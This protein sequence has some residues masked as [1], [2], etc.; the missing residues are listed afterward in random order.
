[1]STIYNY[2]NRI[3]S[4]KYQNLISN[5][6][7]NPFAIEIIQ[8][9]IDYNIS[10]I[11]VGS[12][13]TNYTEN[14]NDRTFNTT[15]LNKVPYLTMVKQ[16]DNCSLFKLDQTEAK[17]YAEAKSN[18]DK[19][20]FFDVSYAT[21]HVINNENL[22][23]YL[24][25]SGFKKLNSQELETWLQEKITEGNAPNSTLIMTMGTIPDTIADSLNNETLIVKYLRAGGRITWI[26]D[27]PLFYQSHNNGT[28][29]TWG[30]AGA[31]KMLGVDLKIWD[32]NSTVSIITS[33]GEEWGMSLPDFGTSQRP[34]TEKSVSIVLA[35]VQGYASSWLKNYNSTYPNSGFIRYSYVDYDGANDQRNS[36]VVNL[37]TIP[38]EVEK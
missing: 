34:A 14:L 1:M 23:N 33:K 25:H 18:L 3:Y 26:G 13:S 32:F 36:D 31:L 37:A 29:T 12:I 19:R 35:E 15:I 24:D 22:S 30:T 17:M 6:S 27:V 11:Y 20:Y 5:L 4:I 21:F 9:L 7:R 38:F 28:V 8:P 2:D 10:Y 16:V